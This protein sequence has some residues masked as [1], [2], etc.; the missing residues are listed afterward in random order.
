LT[1][2]R[3]RRWLPTAVGLVA[4]A[5]LWA[6]AAHSL[7][8]STVPADLHLPHLDPRA[9]F[10]QA[11]LDRTGSYEQ[12]LEI[13][14]VLAQ[15]ALLAVFVVYAKRGH[16]LMRESAAGPIGTGMLLG[17]LGLGIVW[18]AQ[19]PFGIAGL[20]W[21]RRHHVSH[22]GYVQWIVGDFLGLGGKFLFASF[23]L[24]VAMGLARLVR[25][26]WWIPGAGAFVGLMLLL[27]FV[28]PFL[29][30]STYTV[31]DGPLA[32]D[33][34][35]LARVEGVPGTRVAVQRVRTF[36][37]APNA[38]AVGFG[39][40]RR[41]VLWD[42][43]LGGRFSRREVRIVVAH[44]LG[45]VSR[46]DVLKSVGW[47][48]LFALPTALAIAVATRRRGGMARPEAVP[49]ALL[50]L[51]VLQ[52]A[53][54]PLENIR[55]RRVEAQADWSA[56]QA[57]HDPAAARALFEHFAHLARQEPNPPTWAYILNAD[58]PTLM[59]RLSMVAAWE[60]RHPR[61]TAA[62]G[63]PACRRCGYPH[64]PSPPL[65]GATGS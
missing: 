61:Q 36:T 15:V 65:G 10:S 55:S 21:E 7:W 31:T 18:L 46:D 32:R 6:L 13:D 62:S 5:V 44:E 9:Y 3:A 39:S 52:L 59:Q 47:F 30:P 63:R 19:L 1:G 54:G 27:A 34:R 8:R 2:A 33:A 25:G 60:A 35:A 24:L 4:F 56:L 64:L 37:S 40:T 49:V 17:M 29:L 11:L 26:W 58:H 16:L 42:T 28:T 45:H 51:V 20:W 14:A 43:L 38:E 50:V 41:V 22:A 23:A 53:A 12:F 48:A 57:T